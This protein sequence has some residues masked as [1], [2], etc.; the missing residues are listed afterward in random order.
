MAT[1]AS[2]L[3]T[4][5][6]THR[7]GSQPVLSPLE[8]QYVDFVAWQRQWLSGAVLERELGFWVQQLKGAPVLELPLDR[9]R[10]AQPTF[11][12][13]YLVFA[14]DA[15]RS[16]ALERLSGAQGAT[17]FMTLLAIFQV[18]LYTYSG[19][20]DL[21]VATSIAGRTRAELEGLI[22]FFINRMILR[23]RVSNNETFLS[24]LEQVRD[25]SLASYTHQDVP[26]DLIVEAL[27]INTHPSLSPLC[28]A[29]FV[30]QNMPGSEIR[31][32]GL[33]VELLEL[34]TD[35]SKFDLA[36]VMSEGPAG[37]TGRFEYK[38]ALFDEAT[39]VGMVRRFEHLVQ[40]IV[41]D[42]EVSL[43]RLSIVT[44]RP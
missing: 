38:T 21:C 14:L 9:P 15:E 8:V 27:G 28:Q 26:F 31:L 35:T 7:A 18:L 6:N 22:G 23:A 36:L 30:L 42:P 11:H 3:S 1:I 2:E 13:K 24:L 40:V 34:E 44:I 12:G 39:I 32:D 16:A 17:L 29:M 25:T 19:Q 43:Q 20:S 37:L 5:Y 33:E 10:P 41:G 4:L